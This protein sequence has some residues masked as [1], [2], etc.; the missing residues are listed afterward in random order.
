MSFNKQRMLELA[1]FIEKLKHRRRFPGPAPKDVDSHYFN[2]A[3]FL[4]STACGTVGCIA[5]SC[6]VIQ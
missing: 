3:D 1:D 5:G 4:E 6:L 2:M